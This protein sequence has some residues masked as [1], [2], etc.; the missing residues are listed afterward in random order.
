MAFSVSLVSSDTADPPQH[1]TSAVV[2]F[3]FAHLSPEL[4]AGDVLGM[5][6]GR[7]TRWGCGGRASRDAEAPVK[8]KKR[9]KH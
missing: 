9:E 7:R 4:A 1:L 2:M 5:C 6:L 3:C 8:D